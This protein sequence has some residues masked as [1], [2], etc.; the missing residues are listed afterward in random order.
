MKP[1]IAVLA[2]AMLAGCGVDTATTTATGAAV[3]K[4]EAQEGKRTDE[5]VRQKLEQA[6]EQA[7]RARQSA[8]PDGR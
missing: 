5:A 7:E 4:Q 1:V 3:K 2:V 6:T 8:E